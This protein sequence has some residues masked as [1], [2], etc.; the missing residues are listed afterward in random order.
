MSTIVVLLVQAE[1]LGYCLARILQPFARVLHEVLGLQ[2]IVGVPIGD[3]QNPFHDV[4][5]LHVQEVKPRHAGRSV[6]CRIVGQLQH[7]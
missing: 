1:A 5:W 7:G 2:I 4:L 3:T 6:L